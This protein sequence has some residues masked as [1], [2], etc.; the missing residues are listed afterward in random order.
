M[1]V[2][3]SRTQAGPDRTVKQEQEEISR[4]QPRTNL[5]LPLCITFELPFTE[6]G[7]YEMAEKGDENTM[8]LR[9]NP[10][11]WMY[12]EMYKRKHLFTQPPTE[13]FALLSLSSSFL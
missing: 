5:Y 12:L 1:F 8:Y 11:V 7:K 10:Q 6:V 2:L 9:G 3:L 4:N 13:R